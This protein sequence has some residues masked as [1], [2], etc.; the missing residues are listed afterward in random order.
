[1]YKESGII[2]LL[3]QTPEKLERIDHCPQNSE[4]IWYLILK[5]KLSIK[6]TSIYLNYQCRLNDQ[7]RGKAEKNTN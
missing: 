7:L 5:S 1:M 2:M 3:N 4:E 6:I